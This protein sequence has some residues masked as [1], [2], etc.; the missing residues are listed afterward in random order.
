MKNLFLKLLLVGCSI[1]I[2]AC[3]QDVL[4]SPT[5][6]DTKFSDANNKKAK[7]NGS[8]AVILDRPIWQ[9]SILK[10]IHC[11]FPGRDCF[12]PVIVYPSVAYQRDI[13]RTHIANNTVSTFFTN[14][15]YSQI[16]PDGL[17]AGLLSDLQLGL[18]TVRE[19][20]DDTSS[21]LRY[22][23]AYSNNPDVFDCPEYN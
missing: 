15:N 23:V 6:T 19:A 5:S 9:S 12:N 18:V 2:I 16:F 20:T 14:G 3:S 13:L 8:I 22:R 21:S 11:L 17:H 10:S 7:N 4:Q 1:S